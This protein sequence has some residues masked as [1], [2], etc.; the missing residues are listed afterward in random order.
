MLFKPIDSNG[1]FDAIAIQ[2]FFV[3]DTFKPQ[4]FSP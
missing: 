4:V 1:G 3:Y 2:V